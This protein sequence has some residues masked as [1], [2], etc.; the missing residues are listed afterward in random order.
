M[1]TGDDTGENQVTDAGT[2]TAAGHDSESFQEKLA[3]IRSEQHQIAVR[4]NSDTEENDVT[5][6]G[7]K[8]AAE[9]DSESFQEKLARIRVEQQ[10]V[11]VRANSDAVPSPTLNEESF[12]AK[13]TQ[14]EA[15]G[16]EQTDNGNQ[17]LMQAEDPHSVSLMEESIALR[18]QEALELLS[19]AVQ[20]GL[21]RRNKVTG[22]IH[23]SVG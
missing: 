8:P 17:E 11:A 20:A 22:K 3:R 6:A 23:T 16:T 14:T 18:M 2:K 5:D 15:K 21:E 12:Q 7:T 9:P 1:L 4:S 13:L 19:K 10:K